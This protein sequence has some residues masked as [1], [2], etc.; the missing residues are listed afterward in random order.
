[1]AKL[2]KETVDDVSIAN[3][4]EHTD[5]IE[6]E[7]FICYECGRFHETPYGDRGAP[8]QHWCRRDMIDAA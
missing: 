6:Q 2:P 4:M 5:T 1:M 3:T 8:M 7:G